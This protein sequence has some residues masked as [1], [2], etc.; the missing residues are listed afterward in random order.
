MAAASTDRTIHFVDR[1]DE[2]D[3][4]TPP[5]PIFLTYYPAPD[6]ITAIDDHDASVLYVVE[7]PIDILR[8]QMRELNLSQI[9]S[10]RAQTCSAVAN[11]M[12][13]RA[14]RVRYVRRESRSPVSAVIEKIATHLKLPLADAEKPAVLDELSN[15]LGPD[16]ILEDILAVAKG[17]YQPQARAGRTGLVDQIE[18]C[19]LQVMEPMIAMAFGDAT[20]PI[21]WPTNVFKFADPIE[22]PEATM[23]D[24]GGPVRNIFYGPYFHLPPC[25]YRMEALIAFSEDVRDIPF[26]IEVV[27]NGLVTHARIENRRADNYRGYCE[28]TNT[29]PISTIEVRLRNDQFVEHGRLRL[30]EMAFFK[31]PEEADRRN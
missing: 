14:D 10:I 27:G 4:S 18:L 3:F 5:R 12:I 16:A 25:R 1:Q 13:G 8:Y 19:A 21:V 29:D 24:I 23:T 31:L 15:G 9:E 22:Q 6:L 26:R 30:I 2:I 17:N 11:P 20:R 28:F 7:D